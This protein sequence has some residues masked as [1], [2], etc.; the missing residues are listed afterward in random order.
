MHT[1]FP[2]S[3]MPRLVSALGLGLIFVVVALAGTTALRQTSGSPGV[4]TLGEDDRG[5]GRLSR[6]P[7]IE[8][9]LSFR[10]SG[11]IDVDSP[12]PS[13]Q[14]TTVAYRGSG[15]ITVPLTA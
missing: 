7:A 11:R 8:N 4:A 12:A 2:C 1:F 15:R 6:L 13:T 3:P 14:A 9:E 5:S 10:G